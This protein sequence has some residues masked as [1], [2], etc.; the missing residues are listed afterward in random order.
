M[1]K[2]LIASAAVAV[3]LTAATAS[4]SLYQNMG[5]LEQGLN[6]VQKGYLYN[7]P[8]LLQNGVDTLVKAQNKLTT[9]DMRSTLPKGANTTA[10]D[11]LT[12]SMNENINALQKAVDENHPA[13]AVEA[14]S[15]VVRDCISCHI[16]IRD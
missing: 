11:N 9:K 3:S 2:M 14:Y 5:L 7:S 16:A 12:E 1:K 10:V 4:S 6:N 13:A 8:E 15:N